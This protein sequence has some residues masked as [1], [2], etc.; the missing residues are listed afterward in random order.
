[1]IIIITIVVN[2]AVVIIDLADTINI[3]PPA[4]P[5]Y[6]CD[7]CATQI[8]IRRRRR[9]GRRSSIINN[10]KKKKRRRKK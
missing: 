10:K 1:M 2:I 3:T 7:L 8:V 5:S 4:L 6:H 9:R